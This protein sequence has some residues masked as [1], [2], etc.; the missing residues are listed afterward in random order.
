MYAY[1]TFIK[2]G[3][4]PKTGGAISWVSTTKNPIFVRD[5]KFEGLKAQYGGAIYVAATNG[6]V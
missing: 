1:S 6:I 2:N 3:G 4:N 5:C